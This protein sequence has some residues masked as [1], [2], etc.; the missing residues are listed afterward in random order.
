MRFARVFGI[1][2]AVDLS[3]TVIALLVTWILYAELWVSDRDSGAVAIL[4]LAI[5]GAVLFFGCLLAHELSH[6]VVAQQL[7]MRVRQ[8]RLFIFGGVSEIEQEA[9]TPRDELL[10]TIAGPAMSLLLAGGFFAAALVVPSSAGAVDRVLELLAL[11]NLALGLFNLVP[12]FPLDGGRVL[13]AL[14]WRATG[15]YR[16]ATTVAVNAGRVVAGLLVAAGVA[17]IVFARTLEGLWWIGIGWFLFRAAGASLTR[18]RMEEALRG[19]AVEDVMVPVPP[20]IADATML[21]TLMADRGP[22]RRPFTMMVV[23][24]GRVVGSIDRARVR[25][26]P[27]DRWGDVSVATAMRPL[28]P[29]DVVDAGLPAAELMSRFDRSRRRVVVVREGRVVGVVAAAELA[30]RA[31]TRGVVRP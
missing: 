27:R 2:L 20:T 4:L 12:G 29:R 30:E 28:G 19:V 13:R 25:R 5:G 23:A 7:G 14:L 10:I 9:G 18:I 22:G 24:R 26:V 3:W 16:W 21:D 17:I 8:I 6:S 11:I 31:R 1:P 15:S